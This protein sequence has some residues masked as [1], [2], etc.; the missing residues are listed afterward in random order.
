MLS[1]AT[2]S[3]ILFALVATSNAFDCNPV[4]C[5]LACPFGFEVD[6][7]GCPYCSCRQTSGACVDPIFGYNCGAIDHR[8]CP[9]SHTCQLTSSG[10]SGQCCVR[11]SSSSTVSPKSTT[12]Q[13]G[14]SP[15]TARGTT[16][17]SGAS[18]RRSFKRS[19]T[20]VTT[21]GSGSPA[22]SSGSGSPVPT[23]PSSY[24]TDGSSHGQTTS[25]YWFRF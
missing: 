21:S 16:R 13:A 9:S 1:I 14:S 19:F 8:D 18:T 15:S 6:A 23:T 11:T 5:M 22:T 12:H 24:T 4:M 7:R 3:T 10:L 25:G 20:G 2:I 17:A